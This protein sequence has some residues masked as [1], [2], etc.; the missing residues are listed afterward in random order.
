[1]TENMLPAL[2][3]K[4]RAR[5]GRRFEVIEILEGNRARLQVISPVGFRQRRWTTISLRD[6]GP[7]CFLMEIKEIGP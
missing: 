1:M 6:F 2:W 4:W 5:D 7:G 3:S